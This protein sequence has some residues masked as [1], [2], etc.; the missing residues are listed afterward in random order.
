[1]KTKQQEIEFIG[2]PDKWPKWPLLP[3]VNGE[4]IAVLTFDGEE[5]VM[6]HGVNLWKFDGTKTKEY[7]STI[8]TS[9]EQVY[10][11]GWRVD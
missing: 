2:D 6:Y 9:A 3:L 1:M 11:A 5:F 7:D 10:N 4:K 8:F